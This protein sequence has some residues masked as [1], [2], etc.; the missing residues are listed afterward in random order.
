MSSQNGFPAAGAGD[1]SRLRW[2]RRGPV[3]ARGSAHDPARTTRWQAATGLL[4]ALLLAACV[5]AEGAA[6]VAASA[7]TSPLAASAPPEDPLLAFV[8]GAAPGSE[9]VVNGEPVRIARAYAAASGRECREVLFGFGVQ[10]RA[11]LVC[12]DPDLGWMRARPLLNAGGAAR[13]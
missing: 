3:P 11:G 6:P 4:A 9:G 1:R 2:S 13:P 10:E 8:A 12:R 5:P 7:V